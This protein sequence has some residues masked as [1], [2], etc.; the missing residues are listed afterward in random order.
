MTKKYTPDNPKR[1]KICG[2]IIPNLRRYCDAC[3]MQVARDDKKDYHKNYHKPAR[4]CAIC[5]APCRHNQTYC[6]DYC[7]KEAERRRNYD[8]FAHPMGY[9]C[10]PV[11]TMPRGWAMEAERINARRRRK[12]T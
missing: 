1:C 8:R 6:C 7:K 11:Y 12:S 9:C 5:G 3:K 2:A 10:G 4:P